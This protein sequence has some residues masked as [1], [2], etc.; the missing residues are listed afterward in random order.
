LSAPY[1]TEPVNYATYG[2][3]RPAST[4]HRTAVGR[5]SMV[6]MGPPRRPSRGGLSMPRPATW[7]LG[8][9]TKLHRWATDG[10]K[11]APGMGS[12][13]AGC[14]ET[15][16]SGSEER[17]GEPGRPK[18]RNRAPA[19]PLKAGPAGGRL[20]R[21]SSRRRRRDGHRGSQPHQRASKDEHLPMMLAQL[22]IAPRRWRV[23][24]RWGQSCLRPEVE[25][26]GACSPQG[27]ISAMPA[28]G[29]R[30]GR[31]PGWAG[32]NTAKTMSAKP[33]AIPIAF[34]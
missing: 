34:P 1:A 27:A 7:V 11:I 2:A 14:V 4:R 10:I 8:I 29:C 26:P 13:R 33:N 21:P 19:R 17:A 12:W 31:R 15:R 3:E 6:R 30:P 28:P 18:G 22:P 9:Q 25:G 23:G 32:M 20:R 24:P 5:R 16:T